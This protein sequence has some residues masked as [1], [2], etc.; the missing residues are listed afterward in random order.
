MH[1]TNNLDDEYIGSGKRLR[2]SI[3][4]YGKIN[5][6]VEVIEF[7]NSR[8]ELKKRE[9]EIVN[10]NEIAKKDCMNLKTGGDGGFTNDKHRLKAQKAG[11]RA[12][13]ILLGKRHCE[14]LKTDPNYWNKFSLAVKSGHKRRGFGSFENRN[15]TDETKQKMSEIKKGKGLNEKNSQFGT[16]W[17][18]NNKIEKKIKKIDLIIWIQNGWTNGRKN[19]QV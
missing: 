2:C 4:K 10:L 17:I 18:T 8:E 12:V 14:K 6:T 13:R 7:L 3:N 1:S 16:C 5:H 15:H 19:K 11:G 9:S